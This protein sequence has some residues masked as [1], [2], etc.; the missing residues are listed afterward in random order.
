MIKMVE[1]KRTLKN[2]VI[3]IFKKIDEKLFERT[4]QE[5]WEQQNKEI[6]RLRARIIVKER[7]EKKNIKRIRELEREKM[8]RE[9]EIL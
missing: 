4:Y 5:L 9:I 8:E 1:E 3:R 2:I 6:E 7:N